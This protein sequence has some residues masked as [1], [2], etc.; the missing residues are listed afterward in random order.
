MLCYEADESSINVK[1]YLF[2]LLIIFKR[3]LVDIR[4]LG[5]FAI[6]VNHE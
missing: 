5:T 3:N 4:E 1:V 2:R 6:I